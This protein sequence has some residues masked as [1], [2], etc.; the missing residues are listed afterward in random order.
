MID[1][2]PLLYSET[3]NLILLI[4][5]R[6]NRLC[7]KNSGNRKPKQYSLLQKSVFARFEKLRTSFDTSV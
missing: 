7:L 3:E 1:R 4:Q 5:G 2:C 6:E